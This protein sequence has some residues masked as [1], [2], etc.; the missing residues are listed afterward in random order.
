MNVEEFM[1]LQL[2]IRFFEKFL[3]EKTRQTWLIVFYHIFNFPKDNL[4][5]RKLILYEYEI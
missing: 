5:T 4:Y 2:T 3:Q 1:Q